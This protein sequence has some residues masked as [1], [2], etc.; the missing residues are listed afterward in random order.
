MDI[1]K[2]IG[3]I[4]KNILLK[5]INSFKK[6]WVI[7]FTGIV[8]TILNLIIYSLLGTILI[9]PLSILSGIITALITSAFISN[10]LYL[11]YCVI[12]Y[13]R[14]T[15]NDFKAGFTYFLR[16]MYTVLFL[17]YLGNLLLIVVVRAVGSGGTLL[18]LIVYF[19]VFIMLNALPET[20]YLKSHSSWESVVYSIEFMMDNWLNWFI[21]NIIFYVL[22]YFLTG[23]IVT[24]LFSTHLS[25]NMMFD[26]RYILVYLI[27]QAIFTFMMIYRG[28]LFK[29]L[30]TSTRRKRMFMN[31]F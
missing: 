28:H 5:T 4:N 29:L 23:N 27:G 12:N 25:F 11:I 2:D 9:G 17:A 6:G 21:P 19:T 15:I 24:N 20:I 31:K 26:F 22:L 3:Y 8:Y 13:D 10:Y 30:S 1:F 7:L 18:L 16:K 14:V